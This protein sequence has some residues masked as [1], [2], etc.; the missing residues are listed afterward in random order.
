MARKPATGGGSVTSSPT[1]VVIAALVLAFLGAQVALAAQRGG[2]ERASHD[3]V[4]AKASKQQLRGRAADL[5]RQLDALRASHQAQVASLQ[6]QIN[7]L[8]GGGGPAS[9]T[10][11]AGGDL[12]GSYPNPQIAAGAVGSTEV[13]DGSL[14][15]QDLN[16]LNVDGAAGT[17][18]LRR[19][20]TGANQAFPG[21]Q[22]AGGGLTGT[23][24]NP[25]IADGAVHA[26]DLA[27][28]VAR[29]SFHTATDG[30]VTTQSLSCNAGERLLSGGYQLALGSAVTDVQVILN[31]PTG[32]TTW[33]VSVANNAG[34][35]TGDLLFEIRILC[36]SA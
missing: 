22:A 34:G 8:S 28:S 1:L 9:P 2:A 13:E 36:L 6:A 12:T 17:P 21:N 29:N 31:G 24:P 33:I 14:T 18:S 11:A 15:D 16:P 30:A 19:L 35:S 4:H 20:G 10:G 32:A 27:S 25:T 3:G 26:S 5:Q 7:S 23:Y